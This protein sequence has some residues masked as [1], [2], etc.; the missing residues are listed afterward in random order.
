MAYRNEN[1]F[2]IMYADGFKVNYSVAV[3]RMSASWKDNEDKPLELTTY[4][5]LFVDGQGFTGLTIYD[6]D[7]P[8]EK[9]PQWMFQGIPVGFERFVSGVVKWLGEDK[10]L[11]LIEDILGH[12]KYEK[13]YTM[14]Y[15]ANRPL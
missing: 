15:Q 2:E 6:W 12:K 14:Y 3:S 7:G 8:K 1:R 13:E 10:F 4:M 9:K 5:G 11:D